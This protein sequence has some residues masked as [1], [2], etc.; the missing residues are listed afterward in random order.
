MRLLHSR[1]IDCFYESL[2]IGGGLGTLLLLVLQVHISADLRLRRSQSATT[3]ALVGLLRAQVDRGVASS[4]H[5]VVETEGP[6]T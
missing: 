5:S 1:V 2:H 3:L 6:T 4:D